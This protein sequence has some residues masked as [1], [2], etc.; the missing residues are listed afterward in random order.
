MLSETQNEIEK[1]KTKLLDAIAGSSDITFIRNYGNIGDH[2]IHAGTRSLLSGL[3]YK[4]TS[5]LNLSAAGGDLALIS[6]G[7]GWCEAFHH[8]PKYLPLI[9]KKFRRVIVLPSSFDISVEIVREAL[10]KTRALVFARERVSYELIRGLCKADLAHDCAFFFDYSPYAHPQAKKGHGGL[11]TYRMDPEALPGD[12]PPDNNDISMT[13][14][15]LDEWLRIISRYEVIRTDRAH[16]MIAAAMMGKQV[17]YRSSNYHKVEAMAEFALQSFPVVREGELG[18]EQIK[19]RLK[20]EAKE[21]LALLPRDFFARRREVEVTIVMLS[22]RRLDRTI[23]AIKALNENVAIP[24]KLL[25]VDNDSGPEAREKLK[26]VSAAHDFIDLVFL[27]QN[28]GCAGGRDYAMRRVQTRYAMLID[29]D[30][31]VLPGAVEHLL[32]C[33]ETNPQALAATGRVILPDGSIHLCGGGYRIEDGVLNF[34]LFGFGRRFDDWAGESG[35]CQWVPGC[36]TLLRREALID[37][38]Y[39]LGMRNYYEDLEWCYRL[40][41]SD[42]RSGE[43]AFRRVVEST[44]LHYHETKDPNSSLPVEEKRK[45]AMKYIETIAYFYKIHGLVIPNIFNY[46]P[47]LGAQFSPIGR[48]SARIFL[49]LT[50]AH[51]TEWILEKWNSGE[52]APLFSGGFGDERDH[53]ECKRKIAEL[54]KNLVGLEQTLEDIYQSKHWKLFDRYWRFRRAMMSLFTGDN[55]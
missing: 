22:Y 21:N 46:V 40:N 48:L 31:E 11:R 54:E 3:L 5:I 17:F 55:G 29:N 49:T 36:L 43:G 47:E 6:G 25:L 4:E 37:H 12:L 53:Q 7:G 38:P 33:L 45:A 14:E 18:A 44:A 52:L 42:V 10:A 30:I 50:N 15:S 8:M 28:R 27:D 39:D 41:Q 9:E 24:F 35:P 19:E 23:S 26:E 20:L 13:C 16:V 2:L 1:S 32:R 51:G 34:E